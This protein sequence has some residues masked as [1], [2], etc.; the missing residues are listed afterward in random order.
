MTPTP[1]H[2]ETKENGMLSCVFPTPN[3]SCFFP[4]SQFTRPQGSPLSPRCVPPNV[5]PPTWMTSA[6]HILSPAATLTC[7]T[8]M[9]QQVWELASCQLG[10]WQVPSVPFSGLDSEGVIYSENSMKKITFPTPAQLSMW[11][12]HEQHSTA[13]NI[14]FFIF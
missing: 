9:E 13:P 2:Q 11:M 7:A 12:P 8:S 3:C 10:S 1:G 5:N 14:Y 6:W 4:F